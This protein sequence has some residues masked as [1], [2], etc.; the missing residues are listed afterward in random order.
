MN[1]QALCGASLLPSSERVTE[2]D[3]T[4][5]LKLRDGTGSRVPDGGGAA[6]PLGARQQTAPILAFNKLPLF[7]LVYMFAFTIV[8]LPLSTVCRFLRPAG[9]ASSTFV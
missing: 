1:I 6:T 4:K 8:M 5:D 7:R 9:H 2:Q 3:V